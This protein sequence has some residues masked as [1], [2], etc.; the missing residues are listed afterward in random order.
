MSGG[1]MPKVYD[2]TVED[3][4]ATLPNVAE[5]TTVMMRMLSVEEVPMMMISGREWGGFTWAQLTVLEGRLPKDGTEHAVVLGQLAAEVL[6]KK[7][8][9]HC[10]D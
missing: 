9:R 7:G 6:K 1:I 5:T 3:Q 4:I 2:A 10:P 8:R